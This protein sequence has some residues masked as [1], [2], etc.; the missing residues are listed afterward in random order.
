MIVASSIYYYFF[1]ALYFLVESFDLL[2]D[3]FPLPSIVDAGY[4]VFIFI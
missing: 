4:P 3:L 2:T 1:Q